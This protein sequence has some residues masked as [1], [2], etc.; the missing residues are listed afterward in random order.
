M[1]YTLFAS[2]FLLFLSCSK[3]KEVDYVAKNDQ[4]IAD[5]VAKNNLTAQ[6]TDSGLYV[7]IN[8]AG[9]GEKPTASDNVTVAYKGYFTDGRVFDQSDAAGISFPL[10]GVIK[11]W[12]EG[13]PYFKVGGSGI[14]LV[15]S[16]L[17]YGSNNYSS[18]PGGSVLIF[19]VKLISIN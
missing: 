16:R 5:Y 7:V 4:E 10:N 8:E 12:T 15:P 6:K 1:K 9:T 11:G 2:V 18:I 3:D 19:D 17:G 13:I 14:L